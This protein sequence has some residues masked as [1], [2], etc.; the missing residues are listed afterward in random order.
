M[1][2]KYLLNTSGNFGMMFAVISAML[3]IGIGAAIDMSS[4]T[5]QKSNLQSMSDS[6]VLA[7]VSSGEDD[8]EALKAIVAKKP[9]TSSTPK[10]NFKF[11]IFS[12]N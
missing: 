3:V 11:F 12:K 6:A 8:L 9:A 2:K 7:A 5:S 10:I 4:M 1:L